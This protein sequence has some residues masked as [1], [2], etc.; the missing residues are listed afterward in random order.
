[1]KSMQ[2]ERFALAQENHGDKTPCT[3]LQDETGAFIQHLQAR[4]HHEQEA[5]HL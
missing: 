1:M 2:N 4:H 3:T 5:L